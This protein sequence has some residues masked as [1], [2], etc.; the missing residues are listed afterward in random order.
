MRVNEFETAILDMGLTPRD[1]RLEKNHVKWF[2]CEGNEDYGI[3]VYD[4][5][6]KALVLVDFEWPEEESSI[7]VE[8]YH[9]KQGM[10][11]GVTING[12]PAQRDSRLDL[13]N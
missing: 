11:L 8:H 13:F 5:H 12:R 7:H 1:V 10:I 6:G 4:S 3:I 2:V 9:D